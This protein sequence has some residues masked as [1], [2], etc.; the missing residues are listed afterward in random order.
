MR[1]LLLIALVAV[2]GC[3]GSPEVSKAR[4]LSRGD[5]Y[6]DRQKYPEALIEYLNVLKIE[7]A[8][9]RAITRGGIAYFE[10]GQVGRALPYLLKARD[11]DPANAEVRARLGTLY[12]LGRRVADA[13]AEAAAILERNP[14]HFEG[15]MLSAATAGTPAEV[16][17]E[18]QRLESARSLYEGRAKFHMALAIL[19]LRKSAP[20]DAERAFHEA[21]AREPKSVDAH[22]ALANFYITRRDAARAEEQYKAAAALGEFGSPARLKLADFYFAMQRPEDGKRVLAEVTAKAPDFLAGW[23]RLAEVA[24]GERRYDDAVTALAPVFKK[25]AADFEGGL[26]R[27]RIHLARGET[28]EAIQDFQALL[29]AE[30]SFAPARYQLALAYAAAGNLQQA[31]AELRDIAGG[32]PDAALLLADLHLQTNAPDAAIEILK[33]VIEKQ[34]GFQAYL[35]LGSAY[36]RKKDPVNAAAAFETIVGKSPKDPRGPYLVGMALLAQN[37][38][39]EAKKRFEDALALLPEYLEPLAQLADMAVAERQPEAAIDRV[40]KQMARAPKSGAIPYLLGKLHE[41]RGDSQRAERA[42]LKALDIQPTLVSPYVALGG[43]Y[44]GSGKYDQALQNV[45]EALKRRPK[46]LGA[47][48]LQGVIYER[49]GDVTGA[50]QAYEKALALEPRFALAANNLAYLYSEH[51]GDKNRALALAELAK[52]MAPD[53]PHISDTLGWILYRRGVYQRALALLKESAR[54]LPDN[55]EIQYHLGMTYAKLGDKPS[56]RQAL[57]R[58]VATPAGFSG[59]DEAKRLLSEL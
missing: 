1:A 41:R 14:R 37:K 22:L 45:G 40:E 48:M 29:K 12:M 50:I 6:F 15:L 44:A 30:P 10:V 19:H 56:A 53:E 31:K 42:Y 18:V 49:K 47:Q 8:N 34:P 35:L 36:L 52:E 28:V 57:A 46:D 59:K 24:F 25:N 20:E 54:K 32:F 17:A 38:R 55:V 7:P 13:R 43:L 4:H 21:I 58:A 2:T 9:A 5:S 16:D 26:L 23:R 3:A 11:L 27:G 33:P 39:A 51:G